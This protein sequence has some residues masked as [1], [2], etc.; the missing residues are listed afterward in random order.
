MH[1]E[2]YIDYDRKDYYNSDRHVECFA[3]RGQ[4]SRHTSETGPEAAVLT[5]YKIFLF[6][7]EVRVFF[8]SLLYQR[9]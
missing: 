8:F 9:G 7:V 1:H 6:S 3:D 2:M 5:H 4:R